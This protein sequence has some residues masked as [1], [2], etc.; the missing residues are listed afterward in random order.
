[1][2]SN[3][4]EENSKLSLGY[5]G[6]L[7]IEIRRESRKQ[8]GKEKHNKINVSIESTEHELSLTSSTPHFE[9]ATSPPSIQTFTIC[10]CMRILALNQKS[11]TRS[12]IVRRSRRPAEQRAHTGEA[13]RGVREGEERRGEVE[14]ERGKG[15][16]RGRGRGES[17]KERERRKTGI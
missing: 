14:R 8:E 16:E 9:R 10:V 12:A 3:V 5:E 7:I 15:R 2:I 17:E 11:L 6:S 1:M 13:W 4:P